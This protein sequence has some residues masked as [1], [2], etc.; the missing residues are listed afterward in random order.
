MKQLYFFT[1]LIV[2]S[3]LFSCN[4][5]EPKPQKEILITIKEGYGGRGFDY[6]VAA[7]LDG[8]I[9]DTAKN[10]QGDLVLYSEKPY[11][12]ET[13]NLLKIS[14]GIDNRAH[15]YAILNIKK[16]A[17]FSGSD[18]TGHITHIDSEVTLNNLEGVNRYS[19]TSNFGSIDK[20]PLG[21]LTQTFPLTYKSGSSLF[22]TS[23]NGVEEFYD[24]IPANDKK[25]ITIDFSAVNKPLPKKQC[26]ITMENTS[27]YYF[28]IGRTEAGNRSTEYFLRNEPSGTTSF[29]I[30]N[31]G[32]SFAE[33]V[34]IGGVDVNKTE[35]KWMSTRGELPSTFK[36]LDATPTIHINNPTNFKIT[37]TGTFDNYYASF[38]KEDFSL[39]MEVVF[40][41]SLESF[42]LPE[43]ANIIGKP[44]SKLADMKLTALRLEDYDNYTD[45][46]SSFK[47][48]EEG[49]GH[50][51]GNASKLLLYNQYRY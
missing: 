26:A 48:H 4:K 12:F 42:K 16:G 29:A 8:T 39:S 27:S 40:Q 1:T 7:D 11:K 24:F 6:V 43:I 5:D 10:V 3:T 46:P 50:V 45:D 30:P 17:E 37:S 47:F 2:F 36:S 13:F 32:S 15:I 20:Y 14:K 18:D 33:Y 38:A 21:E 34:F 41:S 23:S 51:I 25:E 44:D 9:L 22:I 35:T 31:P 19:V 49:K 28:L